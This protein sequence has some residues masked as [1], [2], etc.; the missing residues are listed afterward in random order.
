MNITQ[1]NMAQ[2]DFTEQEAN[3]LLMIIDQAIKAV[4]LQGAE[5]AV[6]LAKKIQEAFKPATPVVPEVVEAVQVTPENA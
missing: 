6:I 1:I 3:A 2:I 4:G 5:N